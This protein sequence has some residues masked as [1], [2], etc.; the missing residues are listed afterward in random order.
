MTILLVIAGTVLLS[1]ILSY[2]IMFLW[3]ACLVDAI[4]IAKPITWLQ[5]WGLVLL[6]KMFSGVSVEF[7]K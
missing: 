7:N 6:L 3:N 4:T 1:F 2:P 5:A